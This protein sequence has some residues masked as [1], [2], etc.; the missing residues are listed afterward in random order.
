MTY[1]MLPAVRA[2]AAILT[3]ASPLEENMLKEI[4]DPSSYKNPIVV[5]GV[6]L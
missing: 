3:A 2:L 4:C 5:I 6:A 1:K